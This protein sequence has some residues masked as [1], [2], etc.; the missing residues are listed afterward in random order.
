MDSTIYDCDN[1][2]GGDGMVISTMHVTVEVM[3]IPVQL[4]TLTATLP[5]AT[6]KEFEKAPV[7]AGARYVRG[8]TNHRN[9][10]F[11]V[12]LAESIETMKRI[13]SRYCSIIKQCS[14]FRIGLVNA[15]A[16][17]FGVGN[18]S[19]GRLFF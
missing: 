6:E 5:R 1:R 11:V 10:K 16:R 18:N 17:K 3:V 7:I 13:C 15:V 12:E 2:I 14:E 9:F 4:V 19:G 8:S